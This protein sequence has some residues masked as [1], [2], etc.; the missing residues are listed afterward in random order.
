SEDAPDTPSG[1]HAIGHTDTRR[2]AYQL[3]AQL[4]AQSGDQRSRAQALAALAK[5]AERAGDRVASETAAAAAWLAADEPAAALPHGAR[6][7]AS[8]SAAEIPAALR[9]EVL[10]T[11]GEAAWRQRAWPDV[12]RAYRGLLEEQAADTPRQATFRYRLAVAA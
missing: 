3:E 2:R 4:F 10:I 5:L 7:H 8:L 11:L 1:G 9:R 6:A 12:V